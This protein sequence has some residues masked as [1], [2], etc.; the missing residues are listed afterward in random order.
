MNPRAR[1]ALD[2]YLPNVEGQRDGIKEIRVGT[3]CINPE[4]PQDREEQ[5]AD[6]NDAGKDKDVSQDCKDRRSQLAQCRF[7][8]APFLG[9][10]APQDREAPGRA[11][12][13]SEAEISPTLRP[14]DSEAPG[15]QDARGAL[16]LMAVQA[17]SR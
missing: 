14:P 13:S 8:L 17:Q 9:G 5:G 3:S 15:C 2:S 12:C 11:W 10:M 4:V 1:A 7:F 6:D 16:E